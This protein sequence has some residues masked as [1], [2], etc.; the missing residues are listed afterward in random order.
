M[1]EA[2]IARRPERW[3][4]AP[5]VLKRIRPDHAE[6]DE[7]LRRFVLE[8][9]VAS[10]LDHDNLA[11]FREFGRVGACHYLVM[12]MV[13]GHSLHR[14]LDPVFRDDR[15]PPL[16]VALSIG[17]DILAGL[18]AMHAVR[19]EQGRPRPMLHRDVTPSNVIVSDEGRAVII[20]FGITKDVMGPSITMPGKVIGT[21][22]YM[23]PEHRRAEYIDPRADV[24][25]ASVI[26]FELIYGKHPWPPLSTMK[27]LLRVTF[28]PPSVTED[29]AAE[30]PEE[31]AQVILRGLEN[32]RDDRF[33]DAEQMQRA[34]RE[35]RAGQGLLHTPHEEVVRWVD[36]LQLVKDEELSEPVLDV[37]DYG[38]GEA[39]VMW[40]STGALTT[41]EVHYED[42]TAAASEALTIPPLPPRREE[43]LEE[44]TPFDAEVEAALG[45]FAGAKVAALVVGLLVLLGLGWLLSQGML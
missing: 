11:R 3:G 36:G 16:P 1:A 41:D 20:D 7:Y 28:D 39:E 30:V 14:L 35:C 45:G 9:Q 18:A 12:D 24:F 27:E 6:S 5:L 19:D 34:L 40:T 31:I 29:M 23:S 22:R 38:G 44:D 33:L 10:R 4:D 13:R 21:A 2:F 42:P 15:P 37:A 43:A 25:S 8:A 17:A 32:D 26:L